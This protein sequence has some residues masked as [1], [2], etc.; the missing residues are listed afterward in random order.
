MTFETLSSIG[1]DKH[2]PVSLPVQC[3]RP[4]RNEEEMGRN[5]IC[6]QSGLEMFPNDRYRGFS[7]GGHSLE[8]T[9]SVNGCIRAVIQESQE[10]VRD[11]NDSDA[12][13]IR[14]GIENAV[15]NFS[16]FDSYTIDLQLMVF[17]AMKHNIPIFCSTSKV[18]C[19][20]YHL[21]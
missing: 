12:A 3:L 1:C 16:K 5:H 4:V 17:P 13:N 19:Q 11:M 7:I 20:V 18:T 21:L 15:V 14:G 6:W 2:V 10:L 8:G 9:W